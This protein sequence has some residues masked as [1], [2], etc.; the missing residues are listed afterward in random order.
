MPS[1]IYTRLETLLARTG[2][3]GPIAKAEAAAEAEALDGVKTYM[4]ALEKGIFLADATG[5]YLRRF[6]HE[7]RPVASKSTADDMAQKMADTPRLFYVSSLADV[8]AQIGLDFT[9]DIPLHFTLKQI[10][11]ENCPTVADEL[12]M[13]LDF[14]PPFTIFSLG[15]SGITWAAFDA[16]ERRFYEHDRTPLNWYI[17]QTIGGNDEQHE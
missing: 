8:L 2:L 17:I 9:T 14:F 1:E 6:Q 10:N 16:L 7:I 13:L 12:R 15:G 5:E 11:A 4:L 3:N